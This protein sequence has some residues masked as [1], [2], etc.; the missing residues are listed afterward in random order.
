MEKSF[1][2]G[3]ILPHKIRNCNEC[4]EN[5]LSDE[6]DKLISQNKNYSANPNELKRQTPNEFAH[7]LPKYIT[8]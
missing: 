7:M 4:T 5:I 1:K 3:V 2:R 8:T 6:Y